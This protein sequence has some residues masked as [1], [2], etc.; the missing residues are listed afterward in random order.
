MLEVLDKLI[1]ELEEAIKMAENIG[2]D[3]LAQALAQVQTE[4]IHLR[5]KLILEQ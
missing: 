2:E 1:E 4:V 3:E 5:V